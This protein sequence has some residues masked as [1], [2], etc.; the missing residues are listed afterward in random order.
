[1]TFSGVVRLTNFKKKCCFFGDA[2]HMGRG[3]TVVRVSV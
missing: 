3:G 2:I 1:M